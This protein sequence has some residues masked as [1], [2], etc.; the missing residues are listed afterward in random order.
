[1]TPLET[2]LLEAARRREIHAKAEARLTGE[3]LDRVRRA[4]QKLRRAKLIYVSMK[5]SSAYWGASEAGES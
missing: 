4:I 3:S 2:T 1:M 5:S